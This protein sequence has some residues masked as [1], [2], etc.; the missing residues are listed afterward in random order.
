MNNFHAGWYLLYTLPH[1]E[2]KVYMRLT[3]KYINSFLPTR[4]TLRKWH[5]R[6][7]YI[8]EP[9]FPSYVFIYLDC[10]QHY[11]EGMDV[12]GVLHYVKLGKEIARVNESVINNIRLATEQGKEIEISSDSFQPGQQLVIRE[13][14]LTGLSCEVIQVNQ[15]KKLLIRINLIQRSLLLTLPAEYL[16]AI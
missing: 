10:R 7:R 2:K 11:F 5:D 3:E 4:K 14:P 9:L 16:M 13:G 6:K 15:K 1:H 12:E 8:D